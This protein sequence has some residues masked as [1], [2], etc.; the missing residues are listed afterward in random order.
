MTNTNVNLF[1]LSYPQ[2][3]TNTDTVIVYENGRSGFLGEH[4]CMDG[5]PTL[6]MNE[7]AVGSLALGTADLGPPM[8]DSTGTRPSLLFHGRNLWNPRYRP[9]TPRRASI[10]NKRA[11]AYA[12]PLSQRKF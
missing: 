12:Y 8:S 11:G 3:N 7:F 1:A 2:W 4:S 10:H 5:T 9:P 6:R